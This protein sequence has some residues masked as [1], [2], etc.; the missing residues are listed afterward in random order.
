MI[1]QPYLC[2]IF[3]PDITSYFLITGH[4]NSYPTRVLV[5]LTLPAWNALLPTVLQAPSG[6]H[7]DVT[8]VTYLCVPCLESLVTLLT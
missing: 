4:S 3:L 1:D 8:R 2:F 5:R 6:L 7:S